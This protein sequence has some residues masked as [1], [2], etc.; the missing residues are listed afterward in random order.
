VHLKGDP[1]KARERL[2]WVA[3]ARFG[4]LVKLMVE[5]D[6]DLLKISPKKA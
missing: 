2:G 6:L 3:E 5:A 1:T 4:Q